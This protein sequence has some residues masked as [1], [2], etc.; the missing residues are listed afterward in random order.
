M[1]VSAPPLLALGGPTTSLPFS[2]LTVS[3]ASTVAAAKSTHER[4]SA[5][6]S[7]MRSPP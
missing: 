4:R 7:P 2:S 3:A 5:A 1:P 6:S